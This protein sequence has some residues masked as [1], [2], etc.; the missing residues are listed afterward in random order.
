MMFSD[1]LT[2]YFIIKTNMILLGKSLDSSEE[3]IWVGFP[4][5]GTY[6]DIGHF[7]ENFGGLLWPNLIS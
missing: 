3:S 4:W 5:L 2:I 1:I 6:P 7:I